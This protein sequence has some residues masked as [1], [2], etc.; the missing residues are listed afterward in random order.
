LGFGKDMKCLGLGKRINCS[1]FVK[2]EPKTFKLKTEYFASWR[3]HLEIVEA[4]AHEMF[5]P[6]K[7]HKLFRLCKI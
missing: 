4:P 3:C 5:R 2:S 6:W 7:T 1:G